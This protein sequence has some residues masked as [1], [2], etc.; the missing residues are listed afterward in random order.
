MAN[1]DTSKQQDDKKQK[2]QDLPEKVKPTDD[3]NV[4]G[5]QNTNPAYTAPSDSKR[6]RGLP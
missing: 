6:K 2:F 5:G 3:A 4:K 1:P